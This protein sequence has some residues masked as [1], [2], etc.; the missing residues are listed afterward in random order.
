MDKKY[1][2]PKV[3]R[4]HQKKSNAIRL[5][6]EYINK[7]VSEF[8]NGEEITIEYRD[9]NDV[10]AMCLALVKI[11]NG[12]PTV[13]V[14]VNEND[15]VK[16]VETENEPMDRNSLWLADYDPMDGE[17]NVYEAFISLRDEYK[18]LKE[19]V[20]KHEYALN[21]TLAGGDL[22]LNA[23]KYDL[24]NEYDQEKPA[25]A[26]YDYDYDD[27][28]TAI[29]SYDFY[30]GGSSLRTFSNDTNVLYT[31][32]KY[33]LVLKLYN[34]QGKLVRE[35][36]GLALSFRHAAAVEINERRYLTSNVTGFTSI[37]SDLYIS[38]TKIPNEPYNVHFESDQEPDYIQYSE[39]NVHHMLIKQVE[40]KQIL[41]ENINYLLAPELCWCIG[42][43]TLY[44]K[45]RAKNGTVQ[46]F[47]INGG[48]SDGEDI[49]DDPDTGSTSGDTTAVTYDTTFVVDE[50][51]TLFVTASGQSVYVDENGILNINVGRV[52]EQSGILY[53]DDVTTSGSTPD[54]PTGSTDGSTVIVD[55]TDGTADFGGTTSV[56]NGTLN[57]T[58]QS[59]RGARVTPEGILE[60]IL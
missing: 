43:S 27:T 15:T 50:N 54:V 47:T 19:I 3:F 41:L 49:P 60:I 39:P 57:L 40:T 1:I 58:G 22:L 29:T 6:Q 12:V 53:L 45:A 13:F 9:E 34:R 51:G 38:G 21:N 55:P 11:N 26:A 44:L 5:V 52:D 23:T 14:A 35:P 28:D 31:K 42:D 10:Q 8:L 17:K 46:L 25:D 56:E 33:R 30:V 18:K 16:I 4:A 24:E 36:A 7:H 37:V 20:E 48:S 59:N 2:Q 32:Q